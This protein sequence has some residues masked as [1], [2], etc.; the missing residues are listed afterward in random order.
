M[1]FV[2]AFGFRGCM[3]VSFESDQLRRLLDNIGNDG[4]RLYRRTKLEELIGVAPGTLSPY[5]RDAKAT[6]VYGFELLVDIARSLGWGGCS[7]N[8]RG[9][10]A[11]SATSFID[12][13]LKR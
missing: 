7:A 10:V 4:Y 9:E 11:R 2:F 1:A 13:W 3:K 6:A 5:G 12:G 8:G